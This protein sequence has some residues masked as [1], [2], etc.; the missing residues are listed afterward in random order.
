MASETVTDTR[1]ILDLARAGDGLALRAVRESAA[2]LGTTLAGLVMLVD[3]AV[4][5]LGGGLVH[6]GAT[7]W[8]PMETALRDELID[9]VA[10]VRGPTGR[11]RR[12]ALP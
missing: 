6:A 2:V 9:V 7:W 5:V 4:V 3:P 1:Q 8:E 12:L 11:A 10:D